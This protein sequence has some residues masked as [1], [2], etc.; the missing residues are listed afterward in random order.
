[1]TEQAYV[2]SVRELFLRLPNTHHRFSSSNRRL[3]AELFHRHVSLDIVRSALLLATARRICRAPTA[4]PL[5]PVRSL[6]YFIPV[7]DE[8]LITPLP[9]LYLQYLD[10]KI[11]QHR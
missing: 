9:D 2:R 8:L 1:M 7:I 3:A 11:A 4:P 5:P 10:H 6:H